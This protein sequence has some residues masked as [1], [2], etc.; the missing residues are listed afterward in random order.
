MRL[1][2]V[3]SPKRNSYSLKRKYFSNLQLQYRYIFIPADVN[4]Y[5]S[6]ITFPRM[7]IKFSKGLSYYKNLLFLK[8]SLVIYGLA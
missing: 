6:A 3:S 2:G 4:E 7:S 1:F 8:L 5:S